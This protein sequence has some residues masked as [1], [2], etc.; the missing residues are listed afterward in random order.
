M[1]RCLDLSASDI[2]PA[3]LALCRFGGR[4]CGCGSE[5]GEDE[6]TETDWLTF[7]VEFEVEAVELG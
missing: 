7:L 1:K 6:G 2:P 4:G 3:A 5:S